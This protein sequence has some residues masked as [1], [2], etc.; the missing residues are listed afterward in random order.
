MKISIITVTLNC[1]KYLEQ[2]INSVL[3]QDY[4]DVEYL[5]ID[6][7][8]TDGTVDII[9]KY[10]DRISFW[11]S[12]PDRGMFDALNKGMRH[13]TGDV[14]GM[15]HSDDLF[16]SSSVLSEIARAF[17]ERGVESVYGDLLYV[18]PEDV[19]R[20]YRTWNGRPFHR[21]LFLRGWMPAHPSFYFKRDLLDK[22]GYYKTEYRSS[23]DYEFMLRY[24]YRH[25]VSTFYLPRLIVKMRRGGLSNNDL[26]FRLRANR[27]DYKALKD[28]GVPF[29]FF[30]SILKPL[31]KLHQY[32]RK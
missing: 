15:L 21:T 13:A 20:K 5:I 17:K 26:F 18:Y 9:K 29:A 30:V 32:F 3:A 1:E 16:G 23:S 24:L 8:S 6:G 28:N 4:R 7:G 2:C 25:K 31:S 10:S 12:E 27:M 14:I 22:F 19:N 11:I